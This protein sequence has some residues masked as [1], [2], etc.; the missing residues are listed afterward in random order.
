MDYCIGLLS[1]WSILLSYHFFFD[2]FVDDSHFDLLLCF[3]FNEKMGGETATN[4]YNLANIENSI[5]SG[6]LT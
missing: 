5:H 2:I 3:F 6:N 4:S 1:F